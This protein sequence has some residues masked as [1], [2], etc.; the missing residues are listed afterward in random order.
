MW[1]D[2]R[3]ERVVNLASKLV[4]PRWWGVEVHNPLAR[5]NRLGGREIEKKG[6]PSSGGVQL[7]VALDQCS[8]ERAV[9]LAQLLRPHIQRIE[10][11]TPLVYHYG[12]RLLEQIKVACP[13]LDLVADFK[14]MDAGEYEAEIA[15]E[16]GADIVTVLAC[17]EDQTIHGCLTSA[18]RHRRR[19]MADLISAPA[20][21][22][23][24]LDALGLHEVCV[25]TGVDRQD[26]DE[27][28][29]AL[30]KN[31]GKYIR[32]PLAVAGGVNL[33]SLG[34]I[35]EAKPSVVIVGSAITTAEEP[36][37]VARSMADI[38]ARNAVREA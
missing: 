37:S 27:N 28:P 25:H 30:L 31:V 33:E 18:Q 5:G 2:L 19:V 20:D 22:F 29:L 7:Q 38:I 23:R 11:G 32:T 13:E 4:S 8:A 12:T 21:R 26:L 15:F 14:I 9:E 3:H 17:A 6:H 16:A 10:V 35:L 36:E 34:S 1:F 24:E